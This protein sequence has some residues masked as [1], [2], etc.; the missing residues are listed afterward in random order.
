MS[1]INVIASPIGNLKDITHRAIEELTNA[2]FIICEDT[3]VTGKLLKHYGIKNELVVL[4][5]RNEERRIETI[6]H[7][8]ESGQTGA[9]VSDA[10]TPCISDP[11]ER[12]VNKVIAEGFEV[13]GVPGANA[14]IFALSISGMPSESFIF[15]GFLP[16][17]KGRQKKLKLLAEEERTIIFYESM[18]RIEKL[19]NEL[20]EYMPQRYTAVFRELTKMFE[21]RWEGYPKDIL[22]NLNSKVIKGEFVVIISPPDWKR[23]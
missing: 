12:L 8:L 9:L 10:G 1:K 6:L 4:N 19:L 16:N 3:R 22:E 13:T 14:A 15:E 23:T 21:E 11:G 2:D 17:K 18:Y 7:K 5:A 20:S